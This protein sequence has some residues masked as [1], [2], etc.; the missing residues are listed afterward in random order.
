MYGPV[1]G[2]P[3]EVDAVDV[4]EID[5]IYLRQVVDYPTKY[6]PGTIVVDIENKFLY[7]VEKGGKAIR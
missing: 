4:S 3:F 6:P 7:F 5:P 1:P 2:E